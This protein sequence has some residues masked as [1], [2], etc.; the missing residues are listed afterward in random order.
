MQRS[1]FLKMKFKY[2]FNHKSLAINSIMR[3]KADRRDSGIKQTSSNSQLSIHV[4]AVL[5]FL[6]QDFALKG[7]IKPIW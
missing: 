7:I 3:M 5:T 1:S 2:V 6:S 4:F